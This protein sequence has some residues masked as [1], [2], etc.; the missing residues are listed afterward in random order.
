MAS[1]IAGRRPDER[2]QQALDQQLP[3]DHPSRGAERQPDG[4]LVLARGGLRHQQIGHVGARNQEHERDDGKEHEERLAVTLAESRDARVAG[5]CLERVGDVARLV[6]WA[7][8]LRHGR[9][10]QPG[11][12]RGQSGVDL[13]ERLTRGERPKMRSHH[14]LRR[15]SM[16]SAPRMIASVASG[17]ATSNVRPTSTP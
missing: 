10:S 4:E 16:L 7:P 15:S 14:E 2:E 5:G 11:M 6:L 3:R 13:F 17:T 8:I 1:T 9:L 12:E